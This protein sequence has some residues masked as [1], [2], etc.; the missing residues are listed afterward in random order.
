MGY[1]IFRVSV[2]RANY[3]VTYSFQLVTAH[4]RALF[5][6]LYSFIDS[7]N[8]HS[9]ALHFF[10]HLCVFLVLFFLLIDTGVGRKDQ[11]C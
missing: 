11:M 4:L 2:A 5:C 8:K 1:Q 7:A 6:F 10:L 9:A 3:R